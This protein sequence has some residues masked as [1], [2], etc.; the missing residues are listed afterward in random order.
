M[1]NHVNIDINI[2]KTNRAD[3]IAPGFVNDGGE[4]LGVYDSQ[5]FGTNY[6]GLIF[7]FVSFI[8]IIFM[9]YVRFKSRPKN[10]HKTQK[11]NICH[12]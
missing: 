8:F 1:N 2:I 5:A 7:V 11:G 10:V 9:I 3:L 6:L 4:V 12:I